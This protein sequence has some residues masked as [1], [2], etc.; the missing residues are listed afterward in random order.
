MTQYDTVKQTKSKQKEKVYTCK[1]QN[2]GT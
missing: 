2:T 1:V